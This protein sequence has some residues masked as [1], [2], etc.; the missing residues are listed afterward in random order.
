M[1]RQKNRWLLVQFDFERDILSSCTL[2]ETPTSTPSKTK[3]RKLQQQRSSSSGYLSEVPSSQSIQQVNATDIYR[4][5]QETITQ[6]FGL[7]GAST[8]E[9]QVRMYDPKLRLAIVKTTREDYPAVRSSLT[10]LTGIKQGG[11]VLRVAARTIAV[12]GSA[13]TA[14]N[15]AWEEI[16]KRFYGNENRGDEMG[17]PSGEPWTKKGK[18]EMEKKLQHLEEQLEKIDSAC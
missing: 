8:T 14:R 5:L 11:D 3:K 12:S 13:R 6:N 10:V 18:K 4:S 15:A 7:V 16:Q 1:V 17:Q 2:D 9:V